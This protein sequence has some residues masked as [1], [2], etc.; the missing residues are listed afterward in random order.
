LVN[1]YVMLQLGTLHSTARGAHGTTTPC[2][3]GQLV[4]REVLLPLRMAWS[5]SDSDGCAPPPARQRENAGA[6]HDK[7]GHFPAAGRQ[8]LF[9]MLI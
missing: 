7:I 9:H 8:G 1:E 3:S 5:S 6:R 2:W 4:N